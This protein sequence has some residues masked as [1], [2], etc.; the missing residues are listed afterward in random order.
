MR[1]LNPVDQIFLRLE[2]RNQPMHVGGLQL[3][4]LPENAGP[5]YVRELVATARGFSDVQPP[6][7]RRLKYRFGQPFWVDDDSFDLEYHVRHL[8]LPQPG[9][10]RDL[11][12]LVSMLHGALLDR[13]RPMWETYII[14]GV[15]G[16]RFAVYT[17]FHHS[18]MDGISAMRVMRRSLNNQPSP[19]G[20]L[21]PWALS[22]DGGDTPA[23]RRAPPWRSALKAI[24][25]TG[26]QLAALP[27]VGHEVL[28]A[29]QDARH[30]PG[31][32][33]FKQA[34]SCMLNRRIS[35]SRR[36]AAQSY[37]LSRIKRLAKHYDATVNDIVLAMCASAL[38]E[39]LIEQDA[40]PGQPLIAMLPVSLHT[41]D[42]GTGNNVAMIFASLA[43]DV[44]DPVERLATIRQ[45]VDHWKRRYEAMTSEQILGFTA[46]LGTPAGVNLL[47]GIAPKHQSFNV[48]I[49]N[50]PGPSETLY[51]GDATLEGMYP[52]SIVLDGQALNISM[53]SYQDS[54][55][56]GLIACR[57]SVPS[58]QH[59]LQFLADALDDLE[60]TDVP[61]TGRDGVAAD[62]G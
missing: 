1:L 22:S 7:D 25:A 49:S 11:L 18:I 53:V 30:E 61:H 33:A 62:G 16:N 24:G 51:Y 54:L 39:Y 20:M 57:R 60:P 29:W 27:R 37:S 6:F 2:R 45:S 5:D 59:M 9:A 13:S 40:L 38:R 50:V 32:T 42:S 8:A 44:A 31:F 10:I 52:V 56:F 21:V 12:A 36:F 17:K 35:G 48:V 28:Q 15:T 58:M 14:E 19:G 4:S 23:A 34:P 26:R 55:E 41:A 46:A 3:F 43:T 47:T